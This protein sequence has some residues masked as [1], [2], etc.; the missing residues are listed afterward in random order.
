MGERTVKAKDLKEGDRIHI[1]DDDENRDGTIL[2][3]REAELS[4]EPVID[5]GIELDNG[6]IVNRKRKPDEEFAVIDPE[7]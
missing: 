4:G 3:A 7:G 5:L 1:P 6:G 2:Y